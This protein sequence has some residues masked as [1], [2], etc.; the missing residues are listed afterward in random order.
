MSDTMMIDIELTALLYRLGPVSLR[1]L[2]R[3]IAAY[4]RSENV[5]RINAQVNADGSPYAPRA[6]GGNKPMLLGYAGRIRQRVEMDQAIVGIFGRMGR[7]GAVH[8]QGKTERRVKY[9]SRNLMTLRPDDKAEV[10]NMA[11]MHIAGGAG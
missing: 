6:H 5:S 9:P 2:M 1:Q 4:L 3:K 11:R 10:L 7:F 8:D